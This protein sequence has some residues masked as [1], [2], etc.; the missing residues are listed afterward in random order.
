[1]I[2]A[3]KAVASKDSFIRFDGCEFEVIERSKFCSILWQQKA[4]TPVVDP[5]AREQTRT[6]SAAGICV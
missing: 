5:D 4:K 2:S 3:W 6:V 1:M